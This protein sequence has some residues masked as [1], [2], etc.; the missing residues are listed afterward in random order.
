MENKGNLQHFVENMAVLIG[1]NLRDEYKDGVI[2][3]FQRIQNIAQIV[4]EFELPEEIEIS[5][6]FQP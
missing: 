5:P 4:N 2:A 3:N 1:L 6:T